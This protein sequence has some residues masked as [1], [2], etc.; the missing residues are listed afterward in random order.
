MES[1]IA[2]AVECVRVNALKTS[3]LIQYR[4]T[5]WI[6]RERTRKKTRERMGS[7]ES[8]EKEKELGMGLETGRNK[9][10]AKY[11]MELEIRVREMIP[12]WEEVLRNEPMLETTNV[13]VSL[14]EQLV[15]ALPDI[16]ARTAGNI[17]I[18]VLR[19]GLY[20]PIP[21][22]Q[23]QNDSDPKVQPR[24][25]Y[26]LIAR[27]FEDH[28][29]QAHRSLED[30]MSKMKNLISKGEDDGK[31]IAEIEE[32]LERKT[33]RINILE[34]AEQHW[35]QKMIEN[36]EQLAICREEIDKLSEENGELKQMTVRVRQGR[37]A[38]D[39]KADL[40]TFLYLKMQ[41]LEKE[42][43]S[44]RFSEN[45]AK[46]KIVGLNQQIDSLIDER[47]RF[48]VKVEVLEQAMQTMS[49]EVGDDCTTLS[50]GL[51][52]V[53]SL[54][55][56]DMPQ[57]KIQITN[58]NSEIIPGLDRTDEAGIIVGKGLSDEIPIFLRYEGTIK[59]LA[60]TKGEIERLV[61]K[62]WALKLQSDE[63][64]A[65]NGS[66]PQ[67]L[68]AFFFTYIVSKFK[69]MTPIMEFSYNFCRNLEYYSYDA[70][71]DLFS[72]CL[73][74]DMSE[75]TYYDQM[76]MTSAFRKALDRWS[77]FDVQGRKNK[78]LHRDAWFIFFTF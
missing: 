72:K 15:H 32:L 22:F 54:Q 63:K 21:S 76:H 20:S 5:E 42:T 65:E 66:S 14:L 31:K 27:D 52:R 77:N 78:T 24:L 75:A 57:N 19:H 18:A 4:E 68:P 1:R 51:R 36:Q 59:R 25:P 34:K 61:K 44:L 37:G 28:A 39:N 69:E 62:I 13:A 46:S 35:S 74:R 60:F 56:L 11:A 73:F 67:Q 64:A 7:R 53:I 6:R 71:V 45:I 10:I 55:Q 9:E 30:M 43:A 48:R 12:S 40:D 47:D 70:D 50:S 16:A 58:A 23:A 41:S 49:R 29:L 17:L 8:E 2:H 38:D 33:L 26:F 3:R